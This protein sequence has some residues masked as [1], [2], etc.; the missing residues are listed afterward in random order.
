M[1][2]LAMVGTF[3]GPRNTMFI[4]SVYTRLILLLKDVVETMIHLQNGEC[5]Q[6]QIHNNLTLKSSLFELGANQHLRDL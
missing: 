5:G 1:P 4:I 2:W 6:L 3:T